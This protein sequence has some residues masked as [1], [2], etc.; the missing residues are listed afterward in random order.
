MQIICVVFVLYNNCSQTLHTPLYLTDT[1]PD[2]LCQD[3]VMLFVKQPPKRDWAESL[4][5]YC[6]QGHMRK[7]FFWLLQFFVHFTHLAGQLL[8]TRMVQKIL[9]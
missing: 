4:S 3:S 8:H 7:M 1:T 9:C 2:T 5:G 6:S